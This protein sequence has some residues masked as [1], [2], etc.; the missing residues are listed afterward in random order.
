[1]TGDPRAWPWLVSGLVVGFAAVGVSLAFGARPGAR[2]ADLLLGA[3][4]WGG[5]VAGKL[6]ATIPVGIAFWAIWGEDPPLAAKM[7]VTGLLTGVFEVG[8]TWLLVRW[9]R[10]RE[11]PWNGALA[12][13]I[14]FGCVEAAVLAAGCLMVGLAGLEDPAALPAEAVRNLAGALADTARPWLIVFERTIAVPV[15]AL[16]C[17]W[18]VMAVRG[19]RPALFAASFLLKSALDAV[20]SEG[21]I[22][23]AV[24]E[25]IY[26]AFGAAATV[27]L[28]R[29][30]PRFEALGA[31]AAP[32]P[33]A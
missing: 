6:A 22:P 7:L 14:A 20:P 8:G 12:F 24:Q 23:K 4:G 13:G 18:V 16:C 2:R 21:E 32:P 5:T 30:R 1:M 31:P 9:T 27:V 29:L 33:A 26:G 28:L 15:H 3:A 19:R 17:V 25:S 11:A 10:L